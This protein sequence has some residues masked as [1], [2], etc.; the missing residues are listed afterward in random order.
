MMEDLWRFTSLPGELIVDFFGGTGTTGLAAR[1]RRNVLLLELEDPFFTIEHENKLKLESIYGRTFMALQGDNRKILLTMPGQV[2]H[3]MGSPPYAGA[4]TR[5][6]LT[7]D[8]SDSDRQLT[9]NM[10][11][12]E[13]TASPENLGI[14]NK[15]IYNQRMTRLYQASYD[16][17]K[18]GGTMSVIL[19]DIT[20][21]GVRV[22]L[23]RWLYTTCG[24]IGFQLLAHFRRYMPG[25]SFKAVHKSRGLYVVQDEDIVIWRKPDA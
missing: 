24:R 17:L 2:D 8:S 13:Y 22:P 3:I 14:S 10:M 9:G 25:T 20:R 15:F 7:E 5:K 16:A 23:S 6:A 11:V 12:G 21:D 18:P 19:A 4:M 1:E